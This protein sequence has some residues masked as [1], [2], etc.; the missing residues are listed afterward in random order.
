MYI[1]FYIDRETGYPHIYNHGVSEDEV[2]DV[3][4]S[5]GDDVR[6]SGNSRFAMGQTSGGRYLRVVY[7]RDPY[8]NSVF[9]ITAYQ[10]RGKLLAAYRRQMRRRGR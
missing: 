1:R 6:G 9:V 3:L 2:E 8:P 10:M 7:T 5:P 4:F